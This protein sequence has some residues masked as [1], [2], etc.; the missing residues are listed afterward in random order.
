LA[1]LLAPSVSITVLMTALYAR[2]QSLALVQAGVRGIIPA[3]AG[4]GLLLALQ[5]ARPLIRDSRYEGRPSLAVSI[6]L[7]LGSVGVASRTNVSII[8]V[9]WGAGALGAITHWYRHGA[10][11]RGRGRAA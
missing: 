9:I 8:W 3:A 1:G 7:L 2:V 6:V 4:R 11:T 10:A 5:M